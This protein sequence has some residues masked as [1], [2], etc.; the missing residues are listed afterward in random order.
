MHICL[1]MDNPETPHHPIIAVALQ[2]LSTRHSVRLLDILTLSGAQAIALEATHQPADL[3]LLKS[4]APQALELA[5]SLETA[6][7]QV[8]NSWSSSLACQ[9]RV[10]MTEQ[11]ELARL[12]WPRTRAFTT[13]AE[14]ANDPLLS[15]STTW[16]LI[17][18]SRFSHRGDLVDKL[19]NNE[20]LEALLANWSEEPI[21][22]QEFIA[23]DG[24]DIKLWVIDQQIFAA[25][26][27][28][29]L[30]A[31]ASKEDFPI[32]AAELPVEWHN[33]ALAIGH[34]FKM[35][36]YGV[37]LLITEKGPLIVDVNAFPGF[38]GVPGA[39]EALVD[40]VER[41]LRAKEERA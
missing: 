7:H 33:L 22:F 6:G 34:A 12:P 10:L 9:D 41:L 5:H 18:K 4:H 31:G 3:Y 24:W 23:G 8:V 35:P 30:E 39:S 21:V 1:I 27:R 32:A 19:A 14:A 15:S 20:Q 37:D 25:R 11:M 36:L 17:I 38:R 16:P 2:T 40:L 29:P 26:R 13:L 28:T